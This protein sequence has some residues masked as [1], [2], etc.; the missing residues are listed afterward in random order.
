MWSCN[1]S[2]EPN[3]AVWAI[4]CFLWRFRPEWIGRASNASWDFLWTSISVITSGSEVCVL[5]TAFWRNSSCTTFLGGVFDLC[6]LLFSFF[7]KSTFWCN[8][9]EFWVSAAWLWASVYVLEQSPLSAEWVRSIKDSRTSYCA[10]FTDLSLLET[11]SILVFDML[12]DL[13]RL[14]LATGDG[15]LVPEASRYV[16]WHRDVGDG[17][18][19][20]AGTGRVEDT[21]NRGGSSS[22]EGSADSETGRWRESLGFSLQAE[23]VEG[24]SSFWAG[25]MVM[26]GLT[27]RAGVLYVLDLV[28]G[29]VEAP[30]LCFPRKGPRN[31]LADQSG[32]KD[33][34]P[35]K[36]NGLDFKT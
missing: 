29:R 21:H 24:Q 11:G 1:G 5:V 15:C 19:L 16:P 12:I 34:K 27:D 9:N 2:F 8:T 20:S 30:S 10:S 33:L 23:R 36:G 13:A 26:L 7:T 6:D 3:P 35:K 17:V 32:T 4:L 28:L 14:S 18:S 22:G 31:V 25:E